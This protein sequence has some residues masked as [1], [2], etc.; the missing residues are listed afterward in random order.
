MPTHI[1][2]DACPA[3]WFA[4][5]LTD[6]ETTTEC[7]PDFDSLWTQY[8]DADQILV[9]IP[10]GLPNEGTRGCDAKARTLLGCRGSSVFDAICRPLLD[11]DNYDDANARYRELAGKGLSQQAWSLR[12]K[13]KQV[14]D[15]VQIDLDAPTTL[16]ESHPE[17]CFYALN[18]HQP[19]AYSKKSE[20][21]QDERLQLLKDNLN[22][23]EE[24]YEAALDQYYRKEVARD[25]IIDA[26]VLAI[27]AQ[28]ESLTHVPEQ[29]AETDPWHRIYYPHVSKE[30]AETET[31][32]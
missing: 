12:E 25:D 31:S 8:S 30:E 2:V 28:S 10:M 27:A 24:L 1:G 23:A 6:K 20:R 18:E 29:P 21:G 22:S 9:D 32:R 19:I 5:I 14:N 7:F 17:L 15:V 11:I 16:R 3:G 13:I 4:V 26:M